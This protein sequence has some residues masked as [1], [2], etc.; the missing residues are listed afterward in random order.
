M[1]LNL[2]L[3]GRGEQHSRLWIGDVR[4]ILEV[5]EIPSNLL[6]AKGEGD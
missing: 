4:V 6:R 5:A 1:R 3:T 2:W